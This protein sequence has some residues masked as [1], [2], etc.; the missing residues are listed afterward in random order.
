MTKS[1]QVDPRYRAISEK[2]LAGA[3]PKLQ[4]L[5]YAAWEQMDFLVMDSQRGK[6]AQE[7]AFKLGRSKA[8]FGQSAH[9]WA[10]AI[11]LDL[12]PFPINWNKTEPFKKLQFEIIRPLAKKMG[13]PIR[14]GLDWNMNG[15]ITDES[16]V[17]WPHVELHP[18]RE[19]A[20]KSKP[21]LG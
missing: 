16:F 21:F 5:I 7:M 6:A 11:A 1:V 4:T 15:I 13:I 18:W 9:N 2:R 10:P 14:Q 8:K 19:W 20:K 12:A 17:D 3:H